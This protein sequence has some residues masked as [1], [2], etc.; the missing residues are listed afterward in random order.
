MKMPIAA[1]LAAMWFIAADAR[2]GTVR[3]SGLFAVWQ[4]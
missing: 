1:L 2:R 4:Q 3:Y